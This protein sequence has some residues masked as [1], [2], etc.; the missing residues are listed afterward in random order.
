MARSKW[1]RRDVLRVGGA[2][3]A[4]PY[5]VPSGVLGLDGATSASER[6]V[7]GIVGLGGRA[8][9]IATDCKLIPQM[10]VTAVCD[11]FQPAVD[12][13]VKV[14]GQDQNWST[15]DNI[16]EMF[17]KEKL[18]GIMAE[19]TTH[20]R[21][22]VVVHAMQAGLDT[23]IEKPMCLTIDEGRYMVNAARKYKRVTQVGTQQRSMPMNNWASDLVKNGAIGKIKTVL[24][25][26]FVGPV[27][28]T[29]EPAE[30]LPAGGKEGWWNVWLNQAA[31]RPYH[32]ALQ[33]GW[34][35]WWDYDGGGL[36]YGVTGWGTHS[37]DQIQRALGTDDTGPVEILLEEAVADRPCG[38][39]ETVTEVDQTRLD[40][41]INLAK[42]VVGPRAKIRMWYANGTELR[43]HLD[44]E[45]GPGLGAIFVG[46]KGK[47]EINRDKIA[48][49]KELL[50][51]PENPGPITKPENQY[52]IENWV[53]CIKTRQKCNADIEIGQRAT[54]LCYLVNLAREVGQVGKRL[55]WDPTTER[56][57][58]CDEANKSSYISRPR[59]EGWELPKLA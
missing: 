35:K 2:A 48:G 28:W 47:L 17:E 44:G 34:E 23:Y 58:N 59:R 15:Y 53:E 3:L 50:A 5:L 12:E 52:H 43:L 6:V 20:S 42:P 4:L 19:T 11:C 21:A 46:E 9:S 30:P 26:N 45:W 10:K 32:H 40:Y 33:H 13:F 39:F 16:H 27:A 51:S 37:Y 41:L 25:P 57:T 38:K 1:T 55:K 56:F 14:V 49:P 24:A 29:N 36:C 54:S 7:V 18:D 31:E 22:W 8:R